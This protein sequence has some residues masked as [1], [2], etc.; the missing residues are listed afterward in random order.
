M[1]SLTCEMHINGEQH[2]VGNPR[3]MSGFESRLERVLFKRE[4]RGKASSVA[5]Q[6]QL[7]TAIAASRPRVLVHLICDMSCVHLSF[8]NMLSA[9]AGCGK[10]GRLLRTDRWNEVLVSYNCT[11]GSIVL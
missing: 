5:S 2:C 10:W 4:R 7:S 11:R 1:A 6:Q 9:R 8:N 3:F